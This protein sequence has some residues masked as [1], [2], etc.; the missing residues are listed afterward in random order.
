MRSSFNAG[1]MAAFEATG[2]SSSMGTIG[3]D[4]VGDGGGSAVASSGGP[5]EWAKRMRR[6]QRMTHAV[7]ATAH[8]VRSGDAHGGGSSVNLSEG[9]R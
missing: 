1:G 9:D 5:P 4:L 7:Q 6:S 3:G 8:A 2:G